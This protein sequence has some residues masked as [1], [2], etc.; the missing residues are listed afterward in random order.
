MTSPLICAIHNA[1]NNLASLLLS[2]VSDFD[3]QN[4]YILWPVIE[5]RNLPLFRKLY[6][7]DSSIANHEFSYIN[8]GG[9]TVLMRACDLREGGYTFAGSLQERATEKEIVSDSFDDGEK[10]YQ[11]SEVNAESSELEM[12]GAE[13]DDRGRLAHWLLD[14][15]ADPNITGLGFRTA[16][17]TA[18]ESGKP[19]SLIIALVERGAKVR[20]SDVVSAIR[21][22]RKRLAIYLLKTGQ[23]SNTT[24]VAR[25]AEKRGN[26]DVIEVLEELK[27]QRVEREKKTSSWKIW[28]R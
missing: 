12:E 20:E 11:W 3:V 7:R 21:V 26:K 9:E 1:N 15:G 19:Q 5:T 14:H 18:I 13:E 8:G 24:H 27:I 22:G 23:I 6:E 28:K 17:Q 25:E 16:L 2:A 4:D 10:E